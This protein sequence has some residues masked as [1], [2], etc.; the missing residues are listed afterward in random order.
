MKVNVAEAPVGWSENLNRAYASRL[1]LVCL[2]VW[3]HAADSLIVATMLPSVVAEIGGKALV[4]WTSVLY[5][6]GSIV[7]GT[8]SGLVALTFAA[9]CLISA[10]A[11]TMEILLAGRLLQGLGGGGLTAMS[12]IA[13][14]TLFPARLTARVMAA[15]SALWGASAFLGPL[16]GGTFVT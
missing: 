4:T 8:A 11:P 9:G 3:L 12:F 5:E 7:A 13:T 10:A 14:A 2:G 1:I 16:I 15:I 6:V